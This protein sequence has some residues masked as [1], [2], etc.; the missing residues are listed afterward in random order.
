MKI[1]K[2]ISLFFCIILFLVIGIKVK[3][4][5]KLVNDINIIKKEPIYKIDT[6]KKKFFL[7]LI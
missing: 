5:I 3:S 7:P 6:E 4:N 1:I 2:G